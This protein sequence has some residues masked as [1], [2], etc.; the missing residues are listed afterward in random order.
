[1][2]GCAVI[3]CR[4]RST[5]LSKTKG[6]VSFHRFPKD[7]NI[8]EIW[9][10]A[11]GRGDW[12]PT[13]TSTICSRH[14]TIHDYSTKK[15]G[16]K[17]LREGAIPREN[18]VRIC[19][20]NEKASSVSI[21]PRKRKLVETTH[22]TDDNVIKRTKIQH[23]VASIPSTSTMIENTTGQSLQQILNSLPSTSS[24]SPR[25]DKPQQKLQFKEASVSSSNA[26]TPRK[27]KLKQIIFTK[28]TVI[29]RQRKQIKRIQAQNRRLKKK[30]FKMEDIINDLQSKFSI[31]ELSRRIKQNSRKRKISLGE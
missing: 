6:G 24:T 27:K 28:D 2:P 22:K 15:S 10:D 12:I 5:C 14:F 19:S 16:N 3:T 8:R 26:S 9:I 1:M 21:S 25:K 23:S 18:I 29:K 17:Y 13:K 4:A 31:M 20:V 30:I 11:T 7:P